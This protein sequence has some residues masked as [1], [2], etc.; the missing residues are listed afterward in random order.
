MKKIK[1]EQIFCDSL[2]ALGILTQGDL[3]P[4]TII[5]TSSPKILLDSKNKN[6]I[7]LENNLRGK[8]LE[9][10]QKSIFPLTQEV[11]KRLKK[12]YNKEISII[13]SAQANYFH[14]LLRKVTC[15]DKKDKKKKTLIVSLQTG[16]ND[17]NELVNTKWEEVLK[18]KNIYFQTINV[19][20][21]GEE[22]LN[23][24]NQSIFDHI[25]LNSLN[26]NLFFFYKK[27]KS[28]FSFKKKDNLLLIFREDHLLR[29]VSTYLLKSGVELE[30]FKKTEIK[31]EK[32]DNE[33]F[34]KIKKAIYPIIMNHCKKWVQK[35]FLIH[36]VN[37]Y[38]DKLKQDLDQYNSYSLFFKKF[39]DKISQKILCATSY[40]ALPIYIAL[41]YQTKKK[42]IKLIS[43]QHGINREI[44]SFYSEGMA[45]LENN[46]A[47]LL[48]G[49]N[50]EGKR[51]SDK[52]PFAYGQTKVVGV[53]KQMFSRKKIKSI[54]SL[55][56]KKIFF[57]STRTSSGN[58]N[59]L[60]GF[61]T[62][63]ERV[64]EEMDLV[65]NVLAKLPM[66]IYYKAYPYKDYYVDRDPVHE[67]IDK[68]KNIKLIYT[69]KDMHNFIDDIGLIITSR[70]TSTLSWCI[71]SNIPLIFIDHAKEFR[72]KKNIRKSFEDSL[73]LFDKNKKSFNKDLFTYLNKPYSLIKKDWENKSCNREILIQKFISSNQGKA[74]GKVAADFL[75]TNNYFRKV[76]KCAE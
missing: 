51:I 7:H 69:S 47:D 61:Q 73:I 44:N 59:M 29:E 30:F 8:K 27:F 62:D 76:K 43:T 24:Y 13:A 36:I 11:F 19:K 2:D 52:S 50:F 60:N 48:F 31:I 54:S 17:L 41:S 14:R 46:V 53:P 37:Y 68:S 35:D 23:L 6:L 40:P 42:N 5:K 45:N 63:Y 56:R 71:L 34:K 28:L 70:A 18:G 57:I 16:S 75:L 32:F 3:D 39:L 12:N 58:L 22:N 9:S 72:L 15:L 66:K 33:K 26:T 74:A 20:H 49:N 1:F 64:I 25:N 38:F 55:F 65:K 4:D 67:E 21:F 10:L